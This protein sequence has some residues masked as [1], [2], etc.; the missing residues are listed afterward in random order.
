MRD[1]DDSRTDI[2]YLEQ[3]KPLMDEH[4]AALTAQLERQELLLKRNEAIAE[5]WEKI[6]ARHEKLLTYLDRQ[7]GMD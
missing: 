3:A 4:Q 7:Y 2:R 6:Q 1:A 5:R